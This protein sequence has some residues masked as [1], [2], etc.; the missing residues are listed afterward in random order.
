MGITFPCRAATDALGKHS[1]QIL[2]SSSRKPQPLAKS[3]I[4]TADRQLTH[5]THFVLVEM[6]CHGGS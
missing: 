1:V 5:V 4:Y 3:R 2:Y 6:V